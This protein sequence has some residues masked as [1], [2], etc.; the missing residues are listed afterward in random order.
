MTVG[1]DKNK[2]SNIVRPNLPHFRAL[3]AP[4]LAEMAAYVEISAAK[5]RGEQGGRTISGFKFK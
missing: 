4:R 5:G 1:E 2:V 3:Y